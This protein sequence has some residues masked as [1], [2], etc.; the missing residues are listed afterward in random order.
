MYDT[1]LADRRQIVVRRFGKPG[2]Q[3]IDAPLFHSLFLHDALC[4]QVLHHF[5]VHVP[6][7]VVAA[8]ELERQSHVID[9][10]QV[11]DRR[12]QVV[13]VHPVADDVVRELIR[14]SVLAARRRDGK[15][16]RRRTDLMKIGPVGRSYRIVNFGVGRMDANAGLK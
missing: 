6:Q 12:V 4:R 7:P 10:R 14:L 3:L 5:T 15:T 11:Q 1:G 16:G 2:P 9:P 13:H 8:L